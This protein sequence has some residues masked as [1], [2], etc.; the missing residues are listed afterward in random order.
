MQSELLFLKYKD[1]ALISELSEKELINLGWRIRKRYLRYSDSST[2]G[3]LRSFAD[4]AV[5][6]V[7]PKV[8]H[9]G[10]AYEA[11]LQAQKWRYDREGFTVEPPHTKA[12]DEMDAVL[13]ACAASPNVAAQYLKDEGHLSLALAAD[14]TGYGFHRIIILSMM[15]RVVNKCV[16]PIHEKFLL[17]TT[18]VFVQNLQSEFP[19]IRELECLKNLS[20]DEEVLR[21]F[22]FDVTP[23]TL[24]LT[25]PKDDVSLTRT[26]T[27][28]FEDLSI[29]RFMLVNDAGLIRTV[30]VNKNN[31]FVRELLS[32]DTSQGLATMF[33]N[34][35]ADA[36]EAM[37]NEEQRLADFS[38][39]LAMSLNRIFANNWR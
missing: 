2:A 31:R 29:D 12:W 4:K 16:R 22:G 35:Y 7:A 34:A 39:Y 18:S 36:L 21:A 8:E 20:S 23:E 32:L 38:A 26:F 30:S 37:P 3:A 10:A 11:V 28:K 9:F 24:E 5:D 14:E 6:G 27:V 25:E 15:M 33:F 13:R 17:G 1:I 19:T